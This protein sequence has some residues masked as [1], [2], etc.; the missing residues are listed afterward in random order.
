MSDMKRLAVNR[1]V[2]AVSAVAGIVIYVS[3]RGF[4]W[5]FDAALCTAF[6]F[7]VLG[8]LVA[9]RV[10]HADLLEVSLS[11]AKI[12]LVHVC[13]LVVVVGFTRL[14]FYVKSVAADPTPVQGG[15]IDWDLVVAIAV[16][17]GLASLEKWLILSKREVST[18]K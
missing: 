12:L 8:D 9:D 18:A 15:K 1:V 5:G 7:Y 13:F 10:M 16:A 6:T 17:L 14:L 2:A 4:P 11:P 3:L